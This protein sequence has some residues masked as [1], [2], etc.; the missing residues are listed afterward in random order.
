MR[1][2]EEI[3]QILD[4][5]RRHKL[6]TA[7][8]AF[9]VFWG[10]FM[11]IFLLAA[12]NGLEHGVFNKFKGY[13][14]NSF[15]VIT[16]NTRIPYKGLQVN[17]QITI[18]NTDYKLIEEE[19]KSKIQYIS[20]H[21]PATGGNYQTV[22][23]EKI[24]EQYGIYGVGPQAIF[25]QPVKI[26]VGR[27]IN[28]LD[29]KQ[30]RN[31]ALIGSGVKEEIFKNKPCL[32]K[33]INIDGINYKIIGVFSSLRDG[34]KAGNENLSIY[35]P[36]GTYQRN[37]NKKNEVSSILISPKNRSNIEDEVIVFLK[38]KLKIHPN[39]KAINIYYSTATT[40]RKYQGLFKGIRT[41]IWLV[42][43]G[44]LLSGI[45]SISN[46]MIITIKERT[47]EIGIRKAL[48]A[49]PNVIIKS[50]LFESFIL[51]TIPGYFGLSVGLF[52]VNLLNNI[53]IKL[54]IKNEFFEN[55]HV[56]YKIAIISFLILS[57]FGIIAALIPAR[58]ASLIKPIEALREEG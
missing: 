2:R 5:V 41:F 42:G 38:R 12:G 30:Q 35:I 15:S 19:F 4:L 27:Y 34:E 50:I 11:L 37:F 40:L 46:I 43:F 31:V 44:T 26:E 16:R 8:T 25:I 36:H 55:P 23:S 1:F 20:P 45:I 6:R 17:R 56:S 13:A 52:L 7:L 28:E 21:S 53:I 22:K 18:S 54:N 29:K 48:G 39:D 49:S 14:L 58:H 3:I 33:H 32:L 51:T 9:G 24:K 47:K 10:I 57:V